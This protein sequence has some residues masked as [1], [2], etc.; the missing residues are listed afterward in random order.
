M[1]ARHLA[2]RLGAV[3]SACAAAPQCSVLYGSSTCSRA[4]GCIPKMPRCSSAASLLPDQSGTDQLWAELPPLRGLCH[5]WAT[6]PPCLH[7]WTWQSKPGALCACLAVS[8]AL[9]QNCLTCEHMEQGAASLA[10]EEGMQDLFRCQ[11]LI[12]MQSATH[13]VH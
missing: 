6:R 9:Q 4:A 12:L 7:V 2:H 1:R 13:T 8:R 3:H 11:E 10:R 5:A